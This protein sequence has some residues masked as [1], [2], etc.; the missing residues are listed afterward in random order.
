MDVGVEPPASPPPRRLGRER[1][2]VGIIDRWRKRRRSQGALVLEASPISL[3]RRWRSR[4][5]S[6]NTAS[7]PVTKQDSQAVR[8]E[9]AAGGRGAGSLGAWA[10]APPP[11]LPG[12]KPVARGEEPAEEELS[13]MVGHDV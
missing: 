2:L 3:A 6:E 7:G 9:V 12:P 13:R 5:G 11:V 4:S 1:R 10:N 8:A